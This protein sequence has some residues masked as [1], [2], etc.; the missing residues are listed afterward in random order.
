MNTEEIL[1]C[2]GKALLLTRKIGE[3][4]EVLEPNRWEN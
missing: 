3:E 2:E 4:A 1:T